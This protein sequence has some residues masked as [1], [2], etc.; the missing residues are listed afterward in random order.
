MKDKKINSILNGL[1]ENKN[2]SIQKQEH[3]N[4][5][6]FNDI[7]YLTVIGNPVI[8]ININGSHDRNQDNKSAFRAL[9]NTE[10]LIP[11][12][13]MN[14]EVSFNDK[15]FDLN[16]EYDEAASTFVAKKKGVY[17]FT[18]TLLF[19]PDESESEYEFVMQLRVNG[20][21]VDLE[22]DFTGANARIAGI[23]DLCEIVSLEE[24]D[25]VDIIA[26]ST[27]PGVIFPN[28]RTSFAGVKLI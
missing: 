20:V 12:S 17:L 16:N 6:T 22:M 25:E 2:Q 15:L 13:L 21:A 14:Y 3:Q 1:L 24:G 10:T 28:M 27:V 7:E 23:T 19:L 4:S 18:S 26:L 8:N 9:K 11:N 5:P